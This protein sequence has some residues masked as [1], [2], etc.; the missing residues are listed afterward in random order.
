MFNHF[1]KNRFFKKIFYSIFLISNR[2]S[3]FPTDFLYVL[4]VGSFVSFAIM[5]IQTTNKGLRWKMVSYFSCFLLV[6]SQDSMDSIYDL[7]VKQNFTTSVIP[8]LQV[9]LIAREDL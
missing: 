9:L 6:L 1:D 2:N 8:Q 4:S 7:I 3:D 5:S